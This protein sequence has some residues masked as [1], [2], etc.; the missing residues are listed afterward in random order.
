MEC[1]CAFSRCQSYHL[2]LSETICSKITLD[3]IYSLVDGSD[4]FDS[5]IIKK[6]DSTHNAVRLVQIDVAA[7]GPPESRIDCRLQ[8][9]N[10]LIGID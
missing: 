10:S 2:F 8:A 7:A 4:I 3:R 6:D 9:E 1:S 5:R